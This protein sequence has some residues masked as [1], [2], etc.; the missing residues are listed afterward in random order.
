MDREAT[1][2]PEHSGRMTVPRVGTPPPPEM[3]CP[4]AENWCYTQVNI[5]TVY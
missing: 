4:V 5:L 3:S 1:S 2:A